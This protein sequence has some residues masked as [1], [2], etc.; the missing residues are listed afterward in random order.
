L[1]GKTIARIG[2]HP[3]GFD[4]CGYDS[5]ERLADLTGITVT[6]FELSD[7]FDRARARFRNRLQTW[8]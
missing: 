7:L 5:A 8:A 4:T 2:A 3:D 1:R 6:G